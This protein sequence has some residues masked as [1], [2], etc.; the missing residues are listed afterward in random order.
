MQYRQSLL[1]RTELFTDVEISLSQRSW[2]DNTMR[3]SQI[4]PL[5]LITP[6]RCTKSL[7]VQKHH[8]PNLGV[9]CWSGTGWSQEMRAPKIF[10][11]G[12]IA[13]LKITSH[14]PV[15]WTL[16]PS[17]M[18]FPVPYPSLSPD[19]GT[20]PAHTRPSAKLNDP[21]TPVPLFA[22]GHETGQSEPRRSLRGA[23]SRSSGSF[24]P[25]EKRAEVVIHTTI[26]LQRRGE[27][28]K[29]PRLCWS[30]DSI[31]LTSSKKSWKKWEPG[32]I[33]S[34]LGHSC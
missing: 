22:G 30:L 12:D 7:V 33:S 14:V 5:F 25:R 13:N 32:K 2:K 10:R 31:S 21:E 29:S 15:T 24:I 19:S 4:N 28:G 1:W 18:H 11:E 20:N 26:K 6:S 16:C 3:T 17:A 34:L 9:S 8:M 23:L 27:C